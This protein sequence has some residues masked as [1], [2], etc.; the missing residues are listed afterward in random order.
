M[1]VSARDRAENT[2]KPYRQGC[3]LHG[4]FPT[5]AR[6]DR[7]PN[8]SNAFVECALLQAGGLLWSGFVAWLAD[9]LR[10][11][12]AMVAFFAECRTLG[13]EN[14]AGSGTS[15]KQEE[16][17]V[18]T[19]T[20]LTTGPQAGLPMGLDPAREPETAVWQSAE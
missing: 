5:G 10:E 3:S 2:P 1:R 12:S 18:P 9:P 11:S 8:A 15:R 19:V 14:R 6:R 17:M 4:R 13:R 16:K 20:E 7:V